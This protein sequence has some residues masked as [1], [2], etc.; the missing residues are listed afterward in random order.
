MQASPIRSAFGWFW[1]HLKAL[2]VRGC[3]QSAMS[4]GSLHGWN[5]REERASTLTWQ[6]ALQSGPQFLR[7]QVVPAYW[8][9]SPFFTFFSGNNEP[10]YYFKYIWLLRH[11]RID[12][13][14][15]LQYERVMCGRWDSVAHTPSV[16]G[17]PTTLQSCCGRGSFLT[18]VV[19]LEMLEIP[20]DTTFG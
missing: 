13:F 5:F 3:R 10:L 19:S 18:T 4:V 15:S 20:L 17:W 12:Y 16:S 1:L 6:W 14:S 8:H 2:F 11:V 7:W 9:V